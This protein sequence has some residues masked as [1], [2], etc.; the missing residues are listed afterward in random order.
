MYGK[1]D[2]LSAGDIKLIAADLVGGPTSLY[3]DTEFTQLVYTSTK[4]NQP[5]Q[6][7]NFSLFILTCVYTSHGSF[8]AFV[9]QKLFWETEVA[10]SCLQ[11]KNLLKTLKVAK[12]RGT[13]F[14]GLL[15]IF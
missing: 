3:T 7:Q 13:I 4:T 1:F 2:A 11:Q 9:A 10:L 5:N 12:L 15:R 14:T 6:L 8:V